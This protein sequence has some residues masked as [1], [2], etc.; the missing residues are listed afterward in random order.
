MDD[1]LDH[2][3]TTRSE[4]AAGVWVLVGDKH[5]DNAQALALARALGVA[6]E[7]KVLHYN[8]LHMIPN[9]LMGKSLISLNP[10]LSA[11]LGGAGPDIII[12]SGQRSVPIARVIQAQSMKNKTGRRSK[13]VQIGRPRAPL[14]W[15]DVVITTP[16][17]CLP[18]GKNV[19]ML[20]LPFQRLAAER[21][22]QARR[23]W[24]PV[25]DRHPK[26][27]IGLL[28]GGNVAPFKFDDNSLRE[29]S[30]KALAL[31]RD[32]GGSLFV[33]CG[34]RLPKHAADFLKASVYTC[35][36]HFHV[37]DGDQRR[38]PYAGYLA[39]MDELIVTADSVSM[40]ADAVATGK[41][42]HLF[43]PG[44]SWRGWRL[45][46]DG[47]GWLFNRLTP[48]AVRNKLVRQGV[49]VPRRRTI[50]IAERL[51]A[52]GTACWLGQKALRDK[53]GGTLPVDDFISEVKGRLGL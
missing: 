8:F 11:W 17:Y 51:V 12:A 45:I 10:N 43:R 29:L 38:N 22:A 13:L 52:D 40:I 33:T 21:L 36:G 7:E 46:G 14:E 26:P 42:V 32:R 5:G 19:M 53:A 28:V 18:A 6:F 37:F 4:N 24:Q 35:C 1:G 41:P 23:Q 15:F 48:N 44:R 47:L 39:E 9:W 3:T 49:V 34:R 30:N 50:R 31:C 27:W 16:Q 25:F 2:R 20:D